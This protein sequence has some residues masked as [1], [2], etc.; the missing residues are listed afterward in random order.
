LDTQIRKEY[1]SS[2]KPWPTRSTGKMP[3]GYFSDKAFVAGPKRRGFCGPCSATSSPTGCPAA[4]RL[5]SRVLWQ[6]PPARR[7]AP[8]ACPEQH[9]LSGADEGQAPMIATLERPAHSTWATTDVESRHALE[10]WVDTICTSFLEID[11]DSPDREH[12]S[13]KL[14]QRPFG[15]AT[16]CIVEADAQNIRRTRARIARSRYATFFLLQ[17]RT[18]HARFRQYGRDTQVRAGDCVLVDCREPYLL[19]CLS[20]TRSVALRFPDEWLRNWLPSPEQFAAR[21]FSAT[22]GWGAAL[23]AALSTLD[24]DV[25]TELALPEGVV[26]EQIAALLA[27]AAGPE[28]RASSARDKLLSRLTRTLRDRCHE[29]RLAPGD[30]AD[31]HG[32]SKRYLHYLFAQNTTT[33]GKELMR[34]RLECGQR[35]LADRRFTSLSVSEIS[36][37]CGFVEPSH[38]AR[39]FRKQFGLGPTEFRSAGGR[40]GS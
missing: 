31:A 2:D 24:T 32:I 40:L 29:S 26:A 37:R 34:V 16:L 17:L 27:L 23:A 10:Y 13:A 5:P 39:R 22:A 25:D 33:F 8:P 35:L 20:P 19:D 15:P 1:A 38:F 11:I 9:A 6:P 36:A 30:V 3:F 21:P 4:F 18:G 7:L 14:D 28:G 12:F